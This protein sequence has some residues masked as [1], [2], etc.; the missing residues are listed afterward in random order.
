MK[1]I[2]FA[3][4]GM[5]AVSAT[6]LAAPKKPLTADEMKALVGNGLS[7]DILDLKGGK[8]WTGH[9][10]IKADGTQSGTITMAGKPPPTLSGTWK[11]QSKKFCGVLLP[12]EK[13]E[14]C[15]TWIKTGDKEVTVRI[16]NKDVGF[17][18]W[19]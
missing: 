10:D 2:A 6:A 16:G 11:Q 13:K 3:M 9:V 19:Q 18:R 17:N 4:A 15:E 1:A 12:V 14:V 7:I 5:I 8:Q